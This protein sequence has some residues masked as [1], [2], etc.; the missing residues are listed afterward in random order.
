MGIRKF[1]RK[2]AA[3]V[4]AG[5]ESRR[6]GRNK[7]LLPF[8]GRTLVEYIAG[9]AQ[10][11][12][13]LVT[14]IGPAALYQ[15]LGLPVVEDPGRGAGPLSG[16][17]TALAASEAE[18]TLVVACDMPHLTRHVL[19]ELVDHA[20]AGS[21]DAVLAESTGGRLEPLLAVYRAS[22]APALEAALAEG[23]Y[24]VR[25][26]LAGLQVQRF[27]VDEQYVRN[28]NTPEE[29]ARIEGRERE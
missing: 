27:P 16:I 2:S 29:W 23:R 22:C 15:H 4:L 26:A 13:G 9:E 8:R 11:A 24:K 18:W 17:V 25:E 20:V 14:L 28:A 19:R 10:A 21:A 1:L 7:A 6:M 5:G 12:T 3:A